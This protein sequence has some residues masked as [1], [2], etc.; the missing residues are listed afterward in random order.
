MRKIRISSDSPEVT[1]KIGAR[2][3]TIVG[4][5][6][7]DSAHI[8]ILKG[9]LGSGKTTLVLGFLG[10]FGIKPHAAS[11]TFVIMKRYKPKLK[12]KNLKFK[13]DFIYHLDAY[14]LHSKKD[15]DIL[16][17]GEIVKNP[18]NIILIE[19]PERIKGAFLKNKIAVH[20]SYGKKENERDI[21]FG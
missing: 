18:K 6:L 9:E 8:I 14:R 5:K 4:R 17:F 21:I 1:I 19:W 15:L 12:I 11:P 2:L 16:G 13:I 7:Y 3:A 10:F 20:F